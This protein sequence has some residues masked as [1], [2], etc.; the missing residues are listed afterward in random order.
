MV[1]RDFVCAGG[2][3]AAVLAVADDGTADGGELGAD[4]VVSTCFEVDFYV[5]VVFEL[6]EEFVVEAGDFGLGVR[7]GD[8]TGAVFVVEKVVF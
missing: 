5:G 1:Q 6:L 3:G 2:R 7:G 8:D 4:L